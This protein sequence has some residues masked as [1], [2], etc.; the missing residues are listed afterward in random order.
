MNVHNKIVKNLIRDAKF[1]FYLFNIQQFFVINTN[2]LNILT[3]S[4]Y[5]TMKNSPQV[6]NFSRFD[7]T[8]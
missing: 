3:I 5:E 2:L 6:F 4:D 7:L 1:Y 8:V